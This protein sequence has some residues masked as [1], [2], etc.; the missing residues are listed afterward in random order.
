MKACRKSIYRC[1]EESGAKS[2]NLCPYGVDEISPNP[3]SGV[4]MLAA[5]DALPTFSRMG[6]SR[7]LM[8]KRQPCSVCFPKLNIR[9]SH[10]NAFGVKRKTVAKAHSEL[11][12]RITGQAAAQYIEGQRDKICK[13]T[14]NECPCKG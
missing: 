8:I 7:I 5:Y 11:L 9:D 13:W 1:L 2:L 10:S 14:T 4:A 6:P 3:E 12:I